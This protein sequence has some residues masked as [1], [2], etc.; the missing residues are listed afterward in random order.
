MAYLA[1][2]KCSGRVGIRGYLNVAS[3]L[4]CSG[5][6]V[7]HLRLCDLQNSYLDLGRSFSPAN[8]M[9]NFAESVNLGSEIWA[10]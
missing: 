4:Q 9:Q 6:P 2:F 10:N 5:C 3:P 7:L 8:V 1:S